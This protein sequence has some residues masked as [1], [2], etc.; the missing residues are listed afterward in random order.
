M[1]TNKMDI[2]RFQKYK[3]SNKNN[4]SKK[5]KKK[6]NKKNNWEN[7]IVLLTKIKIIKSKKD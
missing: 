7:K 4:W 1:I 2:L 6:K 3:K 5:K